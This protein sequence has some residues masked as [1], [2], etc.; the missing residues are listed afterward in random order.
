MALSVICLAGPGGVGKST[1]AKQLVKSFKKLYTNLHV[2]SMAFADPLYSTVSNLVG[3]P[4]DLLKS[5]DYKEVVWTEETAPMPALI[6]WTPRQLL[7]K[8][9]TECFRQNIHSDFW[10]Q[11]ALRQAYI[12]NLD[13]VIMEDARFD[14]EYAMATINIELK[15]DGIQ[16]A[17][18]HP[19]A[20][21]PTPSLMHVTLELTPDIDYDKYAILC[22]NIIKDKGL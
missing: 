20:M 13:I 9:G 14:N 21:P 4:V 7:Q 22:Y 18:N 8:V 3:L 19:S 12:R 17:C 1:T 15:R 10:V 11:S 16:Y 5:Q 6:G 2:D